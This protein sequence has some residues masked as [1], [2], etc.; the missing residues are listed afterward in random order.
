MEQSRGSGAS[1]GEAISE[2][3][4]DKARSPEPNSSKA[5]HSWSQPAGKD[6]PGT[7]LWGLEQHKLL[8]SQLAE[9]HPSGT[10]GKFLCPLSHLI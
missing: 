2:I 5:A 1:Y 7:V 8:C 4:G 6:A 9:Q 10:E 3:K